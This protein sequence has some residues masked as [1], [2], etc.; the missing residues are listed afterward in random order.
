MAFLNLGLN[1]HLVF[2]WPWICTYIHLEKDRDPFVL[3]PIGTGCSLGLLCSCDSTSLRQHLGNFLCPHSVLKPLLPRICAFLFHSLIPSFGGVHPSGTFWKG[4]TLCHC[5]DCRLSASSLMGLSKQE[6]WSELSFPSPGDL[7]HQ[8]IK[9]T[10]PAC[11]RILYCWAT[12]EAPKELMEGNS[13][14]L[15]GVKKTLFYLHIQLIF[16]QGREF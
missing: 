7:L 5:M 9:P 2:T 13:E 1:Q 6:Y 16:Q 8:R 15:A 11:R 3:A 12:R 10:S 4:G 14:A